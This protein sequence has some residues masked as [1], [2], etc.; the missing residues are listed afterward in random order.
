MWASNDDPPACWICYERAFV[1]EAG[2]HSAGPLL[3]ACACRGPDASFS[4]LPCLV[5]YAGANGTASRR[6]S[7]RQCPTCKQDY[8]GEL[9]L[10]LARARWELVRGRAVEDGE[11]LEAV[12]DLA[13]AL[14]DA[15]DFDGALPLFEEALAVERRI[16]GDDHPGTLTSICNLATLHSAM[17]NDGLALPLY[18]E[19]LANSRRVLGDEDRATLTVIGNVAAMHS[20]MGTHGLALPLYKEALAGRRRVLGNAHPHTLHALYNMAI[21]RDNMG[22]HAAAATLMREALAGRRRVLGEDHPSTQ[23][24]IAA[25]DKIEEMLAEKAAVAAVAEEEE[26]DGEEGG[27]EEEEDG[28]AGGEEEEEDGEEGGEEEEQD[29]EEEGEE[30]TMYQRLA[31]RHRRA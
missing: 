11:R 24:A 20:D 18:T 3:R 2:A 14:H 29:G 16:H 28:E 27:E 1:A 19:A 5:K 10:G 22:E 13:R 26:E 4:H 8:T 30:E 21:L 31:K 9:Q 15:G 12:D 23:A 6:K 17:D 7:W 25:M